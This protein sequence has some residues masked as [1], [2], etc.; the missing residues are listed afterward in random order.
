M[1]NA[2]ARVAVFMEETSAAGFVYKWTHHN[3]SRLRKWGKYSPLNK[4]RKRNVWG[5]DVCVSPLYNSLAHHIVEPAAP[6]FHPD[7]SNEEAPRFSILGNAG[8]GKTTFGKYFA[9]CEAAKGKVVAYE[10]AARGQDVPSTCWIMFKNGIVDCSSMSR[11]TFSAVLRSLARGI[12]RTADG[13]ELVYIADSLV[14]H[15]VKARTV[16]ITSPD[17]RI[18]DQ[19]ERKLLAT[20]LIMSVPSA[21]DMNI[22]WK[23]CYSQLEWTTL[24][25]RMHI[26]GN[27]PRQV[28][29]TANRPE[30]ENRRELEQALRQAATRMDPNHFL[31]R[32]KPAHI[33]NKT[34]SHAL[35]HLRLLEPA[36][37]DSQYPVCRASAGTVSVDVASSFAAEVLLLEYEQTDKAKWTKVFAEHEY[38]AAARGYLLEHRVIVQLCQDDL[39]TRQRSLGSAEHTVKSARQPNQGA[40]VSQVLTKKTR[41]S[42]YGVD[43]IGKRVKRGHIS[44]SG[45]PDLSVNDVLFCPIKRNECAIDF[46]IREGLAQVTVQQSAH[47][48]K[49]PEFIET[50]KVYCSVFGIV[51]PSLLVWT[52]TD[53][54][55]GGEFRIPRMKHAVEGKAGTVGVTEEQWIADYD[56]YDFDVRLVESGPAPAPPPLPAGAVSAHAATPTNVTTTTT[57]TTKHRRRADDDEQPSR[58]NKSSRS[59]DADDARNINRTVYVGNLPPQTD[60]DTLSGHFLR[61]GPFSHCVVCHRAKNTFGFVTFVDGQVAKE[62]VAVEHV[63]GGRTVRVDYAKKQPTTVNDNW[64]RR[65]DEDQRHFRN[66]ERNPR[67]FVF[68]LTDH[69]SDQLRD[70]FGRFGSISRCEVIVD[71]DGRSRGCGLVTFVDACSAASAM[72]Q[73]EHMIGKHRVMVNY[74]VSRT[75]TTNNHAATTTTTT[76]AAAAVRAPQKRRWAADEEGQQRAPKRSRGAGGRNN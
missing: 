18:Y 12:T 62:V 76:T 31:L 19:L 26:V 38:F 68:G 14:P 66:N 73:H 59:Q 47:S 37:R 30:N 49:V 35:F 17:P 10:H 50:A 13:C 34:V 1:P 9:S 8:V 57:T 6:V 3:L 28:F 39:D 42:Y 67:L 36:E 65:P 75:S 71:D 40:V 61:F 16:V 43:E 55:N 72:Q 64:R 46:I 52:S 23:K 58:R 25:D 70:Y 21:D 74:G 33:T 11:P 44:R 63:I 24:V 45:C 32:P 5:S 69:T 7:P 2:Y 15:I 51:K 22:M 4:L 56:R 48:L 29:A 60:E 20:R 53:R 41:I 54:F 27:I